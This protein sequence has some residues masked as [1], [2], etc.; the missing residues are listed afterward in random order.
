MDE[1]LKSDYGMDEHGNEHANE[2]PICLAAAK[3]PRSDAK[4]VW[5]LPPSV[6]KRLSV[7]Y[8]QYEQYER[9]EK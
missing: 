6:F 2:Y 3:C 8:E 1:L 9:Y 7:Q 4:P 5:W